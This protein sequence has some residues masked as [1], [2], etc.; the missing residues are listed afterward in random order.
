LSQS[1]H[2]CLFLLQYERSPG[3]EDTK[4]SDRE[5]SDSSDEGRLRHQLLGMKKVTRLIESW[6]DHANPRTTHAEPALSP[7][8]AL[9]LKSKNCFHDAHEFIEWKQG[10]V[11]GGH[12][13]ITQRTLPT[14][15][16]RASRT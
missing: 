9:S 8:I 12:W 5:D 10:H 14:W 13:S 15:R 11:F 4:R 6:R 3:E 7:Y 16:S 2:G 1:E